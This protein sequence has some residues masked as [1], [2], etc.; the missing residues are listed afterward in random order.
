MAAHDRIMAAIL[1]G[2]WNQHPRAVVHDRARVDSDEVGES[3]D[4]QRGGYVLDAVVEV[5]MQE[6]HSWCCC[7]S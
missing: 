2:V 6:H 3:A 5:T 1:K 4:T 7:S